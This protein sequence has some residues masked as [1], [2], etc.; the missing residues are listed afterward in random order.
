MQYILFAVRMEIFQNH[1]S[2]VLHVTAPSKNYMV[3]D[4]VD[5]AYI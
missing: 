3:R 5:L 2:D 4:K 1:V